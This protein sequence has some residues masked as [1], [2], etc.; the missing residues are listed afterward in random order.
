MCFSV[1]KGIAW[2]CLATIYWLTTNSALAAPLSK[3]PTM[4]ARV[5]F[6]AQPTTCVALHQGRT[7]YRK[8]TLQ[9]QTQSPGNFCIYQKVTNKVI[10]CWK[11][12]QSN[13]TQFNFEAKERVE[14]QLVETERNIVV[15]ETFIDVSWVHKASPR[16]RRWRLF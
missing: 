16:E 12:T 5:E 15:A 6:S 7:C 2:F 14:F 1:S 8:V 4:S 13:Q 9:W 10:Q 3:G 11:N